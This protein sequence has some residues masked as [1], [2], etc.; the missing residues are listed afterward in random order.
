MRKYERGT[1]PHLDKSVHFELRDRGSL[2]ASKGMFHLT[3]IW[4]KDFDYW[5]YSN[6]SKRYL[7]FDGNIRVSKDF[8]WPIEMTDGRDIPCID[9][10]IKDRV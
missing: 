4:G 5:T 8:A 10:T 1:V 6:G 2:A 9:S 3:W 7:D